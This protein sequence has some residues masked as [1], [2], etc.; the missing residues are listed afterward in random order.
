MKHQQ[1]N[2]PNKQH[3]KQIHFTLVCTSF[4]LRLLSSAD[5]PS[6]VFLL[7]DIFAFWNP[8][9]RNFEVQNWSVFQVV[10]LRFA[11]SPLTIL[12]EGFLN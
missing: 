10:Q 4:F 2:D 12:Q 11:L 3:T 8:I 7:V 9:R 6:I 5:Q 1:G